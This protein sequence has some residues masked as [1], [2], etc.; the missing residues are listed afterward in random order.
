LGTRAIR[1]GDL[2]WQEGIF[3]N[4]D[5]LVPVMNTTRLRSVTI[6]FRSSTCLGS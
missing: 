2:D 4:Q 5:F 6:S 3:V 1:I